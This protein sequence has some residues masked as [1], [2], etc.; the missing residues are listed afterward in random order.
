MSIGGFSARSLIAP[1]IVMDSAERSARNDD[2]LVTVEDVQVWE[3]Q[4]GSVPKGSIV[5]LYSSWQ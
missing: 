3:Q 4:F 1:T 5:L 2:Y